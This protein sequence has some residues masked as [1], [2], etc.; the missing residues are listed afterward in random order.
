MAGV[1]WSNHIPDLACFFLFLGSYWAFLYI[2]LFVDYRWSISNRTKEYL[3]KEFHLTKEVRLFFVKINFIIAS[4]LFFVLSY[5]W[6]YPKIEKGDLVNPLQIIAQLSCF[7]FYFK[8][9]RSDVRER[10]LILLC[11][12][13][14]IICTIYLKGIHFGL[15]CYIIS[16]L[17]ITS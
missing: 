8:F 3:K 2:F 16:F 9:E 15:L 6:L 10:H 12:T 14:S 4:F 17:Y 13:L 7:F 11:F 1:A 5:H